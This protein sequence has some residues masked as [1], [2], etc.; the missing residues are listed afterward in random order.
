M[1]SDR[2]VN[3]TREKCNRPRIART[4]GWLP[5]FALSHVLLPLARFAG[6][7]LATALE[8]LPDSS[9]KITFAPL[10]SL[11]TRGFVKFSVLP[12]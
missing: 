3:R 9:T 11:C 8:L 1:L 6:V 2:V 10:C 12:A 7:A 5:R 4:N